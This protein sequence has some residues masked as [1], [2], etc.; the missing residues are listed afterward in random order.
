[1]EPT[2]IRLATSE[3]AELQARVRAT[4]SEQRE[5]FRARVILML[6]DGQRPAAVARALNTGAN[7]AGKWRSR[8]VTHRLKGLEDAPRPGKPKSYDEQVETRILGMLDRAPPRG[9][10]K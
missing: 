9:Y 2:P 3:R 10:A 4:K 7:T 5:V 6:A 8:F 1:M